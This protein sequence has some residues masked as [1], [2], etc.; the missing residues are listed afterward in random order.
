MPSSLNGVPVIE[1]RLDEA[2]ELLS[3]WACAQ[4]DAVGIRIL[5]LKGRALSDDG[6]R[7]ARTSADVDVLVD[8][9][10]FDAY[11]DAIVAA[12][13]EEFPST[14]ASAHFTLHSRSFRRDGWPNSFDVHSEYPG[15]LR[16]PAVVFDALWATRRETAFA[17]RT[18]PVPSRAANAMVL[19]LHSLRGTHKQERHRD[20]LAS[21][22]AAS[23]TAA[24]RAELA[25]LA[26]ATGAAYPL[27][28]V[29]AAWGVAVPAETDLIHSEAGKEW[30]RKMAEAEGA[31]A[32]WLLLLW[33]VPW[34][35]KPAVIGR[36]IWPSRTDLTLT[37]PDIPD[38]PWPLLRARAARWGRG[39]RRSPAALR[40]LRRPRRTS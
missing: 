25:A 24:E 1:L 30:R 9:R 19:A 31:A 40:A 5:L 26:T 14:F 17:H 2:N 32:S 35:D 15:F 22:T 12:A 23:F 38:R 33:R 7:P 16:A 36:A 29:L 34:R 21:V 37:D 4:A 13:W 8:P 20:E 28:D 3:A 11:C 39:L 18:C 6:L 10:A 27:R